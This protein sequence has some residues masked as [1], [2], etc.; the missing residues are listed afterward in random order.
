[1]SDRRAASTDG[2]KLASVFSQI[3]I[4]KI[5]RGATKE[6]VIQQLLRS[7]VNAGLLTQRQ[8]PELV[9]TVMD[10]ERSGTTALGKGLA[11]PHL[12]TEAV[13]RFVGA[14]GLAPEGINFNSIDGDPTRLVFLVLG[15]YEQRERH[16]EL[17]GRLSAMMRDKTTL[18]FLQ[19]RRSP[20]DVFEYLADLDARSAAEL[21]P[22]ATFGNR[23]TMAVS[24]NR[25]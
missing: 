12:R 21:V 8:V 16:F 3:C 9:K 14:V 19:G 22:A 24:A 25:T 2:V 13:H 1:M 11:M 20:R 23:G 4:E 5:P 17:M 7:L 15:P 6:A 18:M 10:R